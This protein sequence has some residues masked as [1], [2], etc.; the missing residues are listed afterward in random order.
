MKATKGIRVRGHMI[1]G[2]FV[3][4]L[5]GIFVVFS[6]W[7]VLLSAQFYHVTVEQTSTHNTQRVLGSYLMNV[8]RG[9]D[10]AES[11]RVEEIEGT[12]ILCFDYDLDGEVYE[13][14]IYYW[15]GYIRELFNSAEQ[16]FNPDYGEKICEAQGFV[17]SLDAD[18]LL[19]MRILDGEGAEQVLH[20]ALRCAENQEG[21]RK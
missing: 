12:D 2:T 8:V 6:T 9:N 14:R 5:L 17:P 20:A 18:G 15:N 16:G 21:M 11:V 3:F 4:L 7:M 19:Q 13:T 10:V 1:S